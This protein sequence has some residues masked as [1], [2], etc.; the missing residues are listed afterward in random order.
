MKTSEQIS[1][2]ISDAGNSAKTLVKCLLQSRP[3]KVTRTVN[4]SLII[5][6][7][8]PSLNDTIAGSAEALEQSDLLAV[9]F[10]AN[11][12]VFRRF[13]P[14]YYLLA[15]P[16]FFTSQAE[17]V[18]Q[19]LQSLKAVDWPMTLFV[20]VNAKVELSNP[21]IRIERFNM[22][23]AEG[24]E[25]LRNRLYRSGLAMPRPRN[26]LIPSIMTAIRMGYKRIYI[27]GADHTWTQTLA[28]NEN[29]EVVSIQPHFYKDGQDELMRTAT[30][31][32]NV[33]L[34]E[35]LESFSIAFKAYHEIARYAKKAGVEI[36]NVTP[37]S[38]IDAFERVTL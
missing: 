4:E 37:G 17:N 11:T 13:K 22:V 38:F 26:V 27:A 29:N 31:Y 2:F 24:F 7:N 6:G 33:R 3:V 32:K 10:A 25:W 23:G 20:P 9:N 28:V 8:G 15:D 19:L 34:H 14:E 35:I 18:L 16:H 36:L 5:M 21:L 12:P 30:V 1:R